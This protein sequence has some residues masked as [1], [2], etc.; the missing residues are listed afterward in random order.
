MAAHAQP[1]LADALARLR[2]EATALPWPER[3]EIVRRL[4]DLL[5]APAPPAVALPLL[6][7]LADDPQPEVRQA[8]ALAL[9]AL[10][11]T[12][13]ARIAAKLA[14]D[15]NA[16]VQKAVER[17]LDRRRRGRAEPGNR[18]QSALPVQND[19]ASME[20]VH[21][22]RAAQQ[23]EQMCAR[24]AEVWA[25][26]TVHSLRGVLTPVKLHAQALMQLTA[27]GTGDPAALSELARKI[28]DR[29]GF[30]ERVLD[31]MR[32]F[33][34]PVAATARR[35]RLS[36]VVAEACATVADFFRA[37]RRDASPVA[38]TISVPD[39]LTIE[40]ARHQIVVALT[41]VLKNAHE[42]F[43]DGSDRF[44]RGSIVVTTSVGGGAVKLIVQDTGPGLA[45][46]DLRELQEFVPGRTTK[47]N[48]GT[49]YGLPIAR[50]YVLAHQGRFSIDSQSGVGTTVTITL[51]LER[52]EVDE[53]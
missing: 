18:A 14:D 32:V 20:R 13:F 16:F 35:E 53:V 48:H 26:T 7:L 19:Y 10:R 2:A 39:D 47:K 12:D 52:E 3:R 9:P 27:K 28:S 1:D 15:R 25:G 36:E 29:I 4:H 38:L 22:R 51:P 41:N 40:L 23:A 37:Q 6:Q 46:E 24:F 44:C 49:G 33:A 30:V 8:V 34:Q 50:R 21:G 5:G 11:E 17:S 31:D 42:A 43:A 45:P